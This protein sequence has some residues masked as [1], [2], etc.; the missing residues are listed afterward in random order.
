MGGGG[1]TYPLH[2]RSRLESMLTSTMGPDDHY[3]E[4]E[5]KKR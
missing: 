1:P 4:E 3:D 2:S 5:R